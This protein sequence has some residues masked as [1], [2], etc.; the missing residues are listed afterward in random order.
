MGKKIYTEFKYVPKSKGNSTIYAPRTV[1]RKPT[2]FEL[3][4]EA[5]ARVHANQNK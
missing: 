5:R 1:P 3:L 4:K 2:L